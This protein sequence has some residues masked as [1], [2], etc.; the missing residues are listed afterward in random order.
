MTERY[1]DISL[2]PITPLAGDAIK[3]L[4]EQY[5]NHAQIAVEGSME[6]FQWLQGWT[7]GN[8]RKERMRI[9]STAKAFQTAE[10]LKNILTLLGQERIL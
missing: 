5:H 7:V 8:D 10:T 4:I 3:S 2:E 1:R 6:Y 9:D